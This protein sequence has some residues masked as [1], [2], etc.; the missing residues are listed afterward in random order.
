M[1]STRSTLLLAALATL[2]ACTDDLATTAE[3][4]ASAPRSA[5]LM[6][7]RAGT[8]SITAYQHLVSNGNWAPAIDAAQHD[9]GTVEFPNGTYAMS[10]PV[11]LL[12]GTRLLGTG[13]TISYTGPRYAF[14]AKGTPSAFIT[15]IALEGLKVEGTRSQQQVVLRVEH[16]RNV[17]VHQ[18]TMWRI[19]LVESDIDSAAVPSPA[20]ADLNS[21]FQVTGNI[22]Y[23][24]RPQF[25]GHPDIW[26]VYLGRAHT[27]YV[28]HNH[29]YDYRVGIQWW[30]GDAKVERN[31]Q[32]HQLPRLAQDWT[33]E[34]NEVKNVQEG[35]WG[36]MGQNI[37]VRNNYVES[38]V[39][40]CLDDEG[41]KYVAFRYN[42]ARHAGQAVLAVFDFAQNTEF[43]GNQVY[44]DG[45]I[46]PPFTTG[47]VDHP[48]VTLFGTSNVRAV[49]AAITIKVDDNDFYYVGASGVGQ[50][51]K[52]ASRRMEFT[53]NTL[54]N[55]VV[56][57]APNNSGALLVSGNQVTL[58]VPTGG[59]PAIRAGGNHAEG[60]EDPGTIDG[61][62]HLVVADNVVESSLRQTGL[63]GIRAVQWSDGPVNSWI[64]HNTIR[65][66]DS[67]VATE[68]SGGG[69]H[70]FRLEYNTLFR[71]S[72]CGFQRVC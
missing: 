66:F 21:D 22:G 51:V 46:W 8:V 65:N 10:T 72:P 33:V 47:D 68:R 30:G 11:N 50:V 37:L 69:Q 18:N 71:D 7:L 26:G 44:Q 5:P 45:R 13:G 28:A 32:F 54:Y 35:I 48:G 56:D 67:A 15:G 52:T 23:G 19:G 62:Y 59:R 42:D 2:A 53:N 9:A 31:G 25:G 60:S 17:A 40:V 34:H 39:D 36:S 58:D 20:R 14:L 3:S 57:L 16:G 55:A 24:E 6:N 12:P 38:C 63:A 70:T 49:S 61:T 29:F 1:R 27:V 43:V 64:H 4:P 41:G